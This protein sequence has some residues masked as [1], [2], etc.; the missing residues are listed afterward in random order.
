MSIVF[1]VVYC[2]AMLATLFDKELDFV[3]S[4]WADLQ[5]LFKIEVAL[6]I[7]YIY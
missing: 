1:L 5:T 6:V 2:F 7:S 3:G 4:F